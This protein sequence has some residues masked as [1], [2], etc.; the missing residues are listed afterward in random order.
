[1]GVGF[2]FCTGAAHTHIS[3]YKLA[4][5]ARARK[6]DARCYAPAQW[7]RTLCAG[8]VVSQNCAQARWFRV[9]GCSYADC[10]DRSSRIHFASSGP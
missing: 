9:I 1:M 7:F 6:P 3:Q 2:V 4:F 10:Q 8:A 5:R